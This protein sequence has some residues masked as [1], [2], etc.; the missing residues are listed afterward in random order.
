MAACK[1]KIL[2]SKLSTCPNEYGYF[3]EDAPFFCLWFLVRD[4][5]TSAY[6]KFSEKLTFCTPWYAHAG[7]HI[8]G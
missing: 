7:M 8:K 2:L 4:H 1:L 6:A 3:N 5:S